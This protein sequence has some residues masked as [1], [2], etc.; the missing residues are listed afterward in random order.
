M[1]KLALIITAVLLANASIVLAAPQDAKKDTKQSAKTEVVTDKQKKSVKG[2]K[3]K[4]CVDKEEKSA[5]KKKDADK[6]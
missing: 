2:K 4:C 5:E 6:K 1:K 3:A